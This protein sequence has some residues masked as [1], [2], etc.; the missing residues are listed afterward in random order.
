MPNQDQDSQESKPNAFTQVMIQ[1]MESLHQKFDSMGD[2][3]HDTLVEF[4]GISRRIDEVL[5]KVNKEAQSNGEQ[6]KRIS[7]L[8]TARSNL[9]TAIA[10]FSGVWAIIGT[11]AVFAFNSYMQNSENRVITASVE[12]TIARIDE[13]YDM[14]F[15]SPNKK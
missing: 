5:E 10:V 3:L 11:V 13:R 15:K 7:K 4:S 8:E 2:K 1:N 6:D 14:Q 12:A 9:L